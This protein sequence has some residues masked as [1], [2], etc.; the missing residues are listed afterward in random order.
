[1]KYLKFIDKHIPSLKG[2]TIIVTGA[3]CG[4]GFATSKQL[5]HKDAKVIMA[6]R[7]L[8]KA[9][10]AKE[11]ILKEFPNA[12]IEI[13][14]YDQADFSSME[15][16]A[17][18]IKDL[19][20]DAILL[21]AGLYHPRDGLRTKDGYPLTVGTNYLGQYY[22]IKQLEPS[23]LNGNIKRLVLVSSL[24]HVFGKTR[25]YEKYLLK[26]TNKPNRTYNVSKRMIYDFASNLKTKYPNLEVVLT[27]PG[28]ASTS[29]I[30]QDQSSLIKFVKK[31]GDIFLK[32]FANNPE[33]SA[34][35]AL[36][37]FADNDANKLKIYRPRGLFH[38]VG[39]PSKKNLKIKE[40]KKLEEVSKSVIS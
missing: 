9:S 11:E 12:E 30:L 39:Y 4:L 6:C 10:K 33:K 38:I 16:F 35:C 28:V 31:G 18:R 8:T 25:H 36:F 21:N 7:N 32:I 27:H 20:I 17:N 3:N 23:I 15:E 34:I 19:K 40:N 37:A 2:K 14:K 24:V 29:I 13:I 22:L 5:V 26:V 1:M